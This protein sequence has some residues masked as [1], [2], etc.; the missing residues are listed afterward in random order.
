MGPFENLKAHLVNLVRDSRWLCT[1]YLYVN[2]Q[3]WLT[4][5]P[6]VNKW[7][8]SP[9]LLIW[10]QFHRHI[11]KNQTVLFPTTFISASEKISVG[12]KKQAANF[13]FNFTGRKVA[14]YSC[15]DFFPQC[16][17]VFTAI[18]AM[19]YLFNISNKTFCNLVYVELYTMLNFPSVCTGD[20]NIYAEYDLRGRFH[21]MV[22]E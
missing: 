18:W 2:I 1:Q 22:Y 3:P 5:H 8:S 7:V 12:L 14:R 13:Q 19:K 9:Y 20:W 17:M 4:R 10:S 21:Y 16:K 6:N 11:L 15:F